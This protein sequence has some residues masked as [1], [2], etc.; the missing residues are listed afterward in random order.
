LG[1]A[2]YEAE[3]VKFL[4]ERARGDVVHA[5][6]F[7]GDFL[8]ALSRAYEQ[9]WAFEP[10]SDSFKCAEIT[11]RLNDLGNVNL[12]NSALGSTARAATLVTERDGQYLG[13]ASFVVDEPG[14]TPIQT[15][16]DVVP[17]A[18]HVGMIHLD[19]EGYEANALE[20][21][22]E[23][24]RRCAPIVVLETLVQIDGYAVSARLGRNFVLMP[25]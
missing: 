10:N 19:V 20:G 14:E 9:V 16:D 6:T 23:T 7:F 5:G 25:A 21:A 18:R 1:G 17:S 2:V 22:R 3:T 13:G 12:R 4:V 15:V 11:I 8:P 24:M